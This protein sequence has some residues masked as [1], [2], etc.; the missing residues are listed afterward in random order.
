MNTANDLQRIESQNDFFRFLEI[1]TEKLVTAVYMITNFLSDKEPMKWRLRDIC[2]STLSNASVLKEKNPSEQ[3][4]LLTGILASTGEIVSLLEIAHLSGF[5]SEMNY[6]VLRREY[7]TMMQQI[8]NR[9]EVKNMVNKVSLPDT[10]FKDIGLEAPSPGTSGSDTY[11]TKASAPYSSA[12]QRKGGYG[13]KDLSPAEGVSGRTSS[14]YGVKDNVVSN[15]Q[16]QNDFLNSY[17]QKDTGGVQGDG[18]R[19]LGRVE[20]TKNKRR[21]III[22]MLRDKKD[23]TIKDITTEITDCS[24]KTIQRELVSLV[25][26]GILKKTGERRW[27]R[28]SLN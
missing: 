28:Y 13:A 16:I 4:N 11:A 25:K 24:E 27:S 3:S 10:L 19:K 12:D 17:D 18:V 14:M 22:Q 21:D 15:G 5:I 8:T 2:L 7:L 20:K 9:D 26:K 6:S 23:L 1:K